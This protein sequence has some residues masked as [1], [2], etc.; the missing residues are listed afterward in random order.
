MGEGGQSRILFFS[1]FRPFIE[2]T[3]AGDD[4]RSPASLTSAR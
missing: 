1:N 2:F 3:R 4:D